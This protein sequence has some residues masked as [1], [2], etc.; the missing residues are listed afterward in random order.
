M[1]RLSHREQRIYLLKTKQLKLN[2]DCL[3]S[4]AQY[5]WLLRLYEHNKQQA[6]MKAAVVPHRF[7][8]E[9]VL[10]QRSGVV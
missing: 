8:K 3:N 2:S 7:K 4:I 6:S 9:T 1:S 10:V 5:A